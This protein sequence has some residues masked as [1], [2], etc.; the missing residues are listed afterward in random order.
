MGLKMEPGHEFQHGENYLYLKI[1]V[2]GAASDEAVYTLDVKRNQHVWILAAAKVNVK[3]QN[4]I[5][6]EPNPELAELGQ[7]QGVYRIH[8]GSGDKELGF[9]FTAR[10]DVDLRSLEY[11]LRV[12][13]PA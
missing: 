2:I 4:F 5:E 12:Y 11:A 10:K 3:G 7:V 6:I 1:P 9:W 13:M 8:P